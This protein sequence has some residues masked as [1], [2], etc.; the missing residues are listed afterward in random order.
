M[1]KDLD[2]KF[3]SSPGYFESI[4][5]LRPTW[6]GSSDL[7]HLLDEPI[8]RRELEAA[9]FELEYVHA[10]PLPWDC[11]QMCCAVVARCRA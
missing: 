8:L 6:D 9:G 10:Y 4:R 1:H 3:E 2:R 7:V 11:D 5:G